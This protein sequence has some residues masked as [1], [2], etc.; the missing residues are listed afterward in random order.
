MIIQGNALTV[1]LAVTWGKHQPKH[2]FLHLVVIKIIL[3]IRMIIVYH[4]K[5][6]RSPYHLKVMIKYVLDIIVLLVIIKILINV[7]LVIQNV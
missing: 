6:V 5:A 3:S 7:Y 1:A 2:V 4:A